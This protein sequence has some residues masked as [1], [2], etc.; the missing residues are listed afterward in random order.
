[1]SQEA[2]LGRSLVSE[3]LSL[4]SRTLKEKLEELSRREHSTNS[5]VAVANLLVRRFLGAGF[6][7]LDR[8]DFGDRIEFK[9][10]IE[11]KVVESDYPLSLDVF[12]GQDSSFEKHSDMVSLYF[13]LVV[14][15]VL[16]QWNPETRTARHPDDVRVGRHDLGCK[17]RF[18]EQARM[19]IEAFPVIVEQRL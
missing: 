2:T 10:R 18:Y 4:E 14:R 13:D 1:M 9:V 19:M 7:L 12:V 11:W 6:R 5:M 15:E 17:P 8:H 3:I 16:A